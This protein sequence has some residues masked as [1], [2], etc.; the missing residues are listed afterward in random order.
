M[1]TKAV[2]VPDRLQVEKEVVP[3][4][5]RVSRQWPLLVAAGTPSLLPT[6]FSSFLYGRWQGAHTKNL[7]LLLG[8]LTIFYWL[9][10]ASWTNCQTKRIFPTFAQHGVDLSLWIVGWNFSAIIQLWSKEA[11]MKL[12]ILSEKM[13]KWWWMI[14]V[15]LSSNNIA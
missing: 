10:C 15:L 4:R 6:F 3:I 1:Y 14:L 13:K 11:N 2:F 9:N 8:G 5:R 12:F 7:V